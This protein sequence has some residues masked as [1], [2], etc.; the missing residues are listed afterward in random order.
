MTKL[1]SG[2]RDTTFCADFLMDFYQA[3][4]A[5]SQLVKLTA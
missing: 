1:L 5:D 4:I 2:W 3:E